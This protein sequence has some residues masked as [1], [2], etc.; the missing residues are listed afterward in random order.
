MPL[1]YQSLSESLAV[2]RLTLGVA[3]IHAVLCGLLAAQAEDARGL[4]LEELLD[5]PLD[6][7]N[8]LLRESAQALEQIYQATS[9]GLAG[10]GEDFIILLPDDDVAFVQRAQALVDWSSGFIYGLGLGGADISALSEDARESLQ[11]ISEFTR[12]EVEE[13]EE[14]EETNEELES[15]FEFLWIS[16]LLVHTELGL[17]H[18]QAR[19]TSS[20]V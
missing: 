13:I 7:S 15:L 6:E 4:W 17:L 12:L 14:T 1:E 5:E 10:L 18:R 2:L 19:Q 16:S 9:S 11:S 8:L 3:E 20:E